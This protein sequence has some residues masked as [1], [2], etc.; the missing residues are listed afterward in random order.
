MWY[1]L[2]IEN[3]LEVKHMYEKR[4]MEKKDI[5][6][7]LDKEQMEA[8]ELERESDRKFRRISLILVIVM[9][10]VATLCIAYALANCKTLSHTEVSVFALIGATSGGIAIERAYSLWKNS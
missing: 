9:T 2:G 7:I 8:H 1:N 4:Q 6:L 5:V 10:V 3:V